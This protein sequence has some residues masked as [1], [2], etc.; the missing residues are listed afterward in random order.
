[1]RLHDFIRKTRF[2]DKSGYCDYIHNMSIASI[3]ELTI[4]QMK[5][6][7]TQSARR[8]TKTGEKRRKILD[9][10]AMV[11]IREGFDTATMS[12]IAAEAGVSV[13]TLYLYFKDKEELRQAV[14]ESRAARVLSGSGEEASRARVFGVERVSMIDSLIDAE[15]ETWFFGKSQG[16]RKR[17]A[18]TRRRMIL[19]AA[20]RVFVRE[21]FYPATISE[22]AAEAGIAVGTLYLYFRKKEDLY[23]KLVEEKIEELL[24]L[25]RAE[26]QGEQGAIGKIRRIVAAE[27][28][29]FARN[30]EY[31]GVHF[32]T[33]SDL[34][35]LLKQS[36]DR[37]YNTC[38]G[39]VTD[40]IRQ[41]IDDGD[42]RS[43]APADLACLL[44]GMINS[45][46]DQ[47]LID[48]SLPS[49]TE[50]ADWLA[51]FFTRAAFS[52]KKR[53]E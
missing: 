7:A 9:A 52:D 15:H 49:L 45:M 8:T 35:I 51:N 18:E 38:M 3:N 2:I 43:A 22:V 36:L 46:L 25:I 20:G 1:M 14:T 37:Q 16:R 28:N 40:I 48:D 4:Q 27:V 11:Y 26:S 42:I 17:E 29:F 53:I 12:Q 23:V 6:T 30:R 41:G 47:W 44:Q 32:L 5:G 13:G 34:P 21:G 33:C 19:E 24:S 10:A 50:K 31:F 39:I